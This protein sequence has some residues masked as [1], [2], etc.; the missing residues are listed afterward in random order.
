MSIESDYISSLEKKIKSLEGSRGYRWTR[1]GRKILE[2][3]ANALNAAMAVP[4]FFNS[5]KREQFAKINYAKYIEDAYKSNYGVVR[6]NDASKYRQKKEPVIISGRWINYPWLHYCV[7][8]RNIEINTNECGSYESLDPEKPTVI[9]VTHD[10]SRTGAPIL[11]YDLLLRYKKSHNV[12]VFSINKGDISCF[13]KDMA[14]VFVEPISRQ[15]IPEIVGVELQLIKAKSDRVHAIV[16]SIVS[17]EILSEFWSYDIPTIHLI[18]E[19]ASYTRPRLRFDDSLFY[20]DA[21]IFSAKIVLA[22][23]ISSSPAIGNVK[24]YVIPQGVCPV[25]N[26]E[27]NK[28]EKE[29]E[30]KYIKKA[31]RPEGWPDDTI[32]VLGAGSV[33]LRK[34]VDLFVSCAKKVL[35]QNPGKNIRFVWIGA[36]YEP[37]TDLYYSCFLED[38]INRTELGDAFSIIKDVNEFDAVYNLVDI[39]FLSSRLD[40]LP[41]VAQ[42]ALFHKLPIVCFDGAGGIPEYLHRDKV[43]SESIVP[44]LD[45]ESA[46]QKITSFIKDK[47]AA[48]KISEA[49]QVLAKQIFDQDRYFLTINKI[50]EEIITDRSNES[51]DIDYIKKNN[52]CNFSYAYPQ[53]SKNASLAV[54]HYVRAWRKGIYLRKPFPGFHPGI[55]Q[56]FHPDCTHDPLI[57]FDA[58]GRRN[59]PWTSEVISP[60]ETQTNPAA[61]TNIKAALHI[62]LHYPEIAGEIFSR[63]RNSEIKPDLFVSVTSEEGKAEVE[64]M[65]QEYSLTYKEIKIVPNRGRDIG[66]LLTGYKEIFESGY[67]FIGHVH[68]KKSVAL[69]GDTGSVWAEFLY[70]NLLGGKHPMMDL[71]LRKMAADSSLG[72]VFPDDPHAMGWNENRDH[73]V[74]L[75]TKMGLN[76]EL[77]KSSLNF[78]VGTMFWSRTDSL[79]PLLDLNLDWDSYPEE[80]VPYDGTILHAIERILPLMSLDRGYRNAVTYVPG[81]TR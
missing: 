20:S 33:H 23:A 19:F 47:D 51:E 39:F 50:H 59:G 41:L 13:F 42:G 21:M 54:K 40:P 73:A 68:G 43:A 9:L 58:T 2:L 26:N 1:P 81:V 62:H 27:I 76:I 77:P 56:D 55:Y 78:P 7:F 49:G 52:L 4:L 45:I 71:I 14:T 60:P 6:S 63:L 74:T 18:H 11:V 72:I 29:D 57:H 28:E 48:L 75:A 79:R 22:D 3:T 70:E 24:E 38:Q 31:L 80:P 15:H 61:P 69:G 64:K 36:G 30:I 34:G 65:L 12:V 35:A 16:N 67:D 66:P 8:N 37:E 32:V 5:K 46:A 53:F 25:P 44:F 17:T 10:T